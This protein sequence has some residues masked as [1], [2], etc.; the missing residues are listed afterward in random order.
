MSTKLVS[1][2]AMT[3]RPIKGIEPTAYVISRDSLKP[4]L[5]EN[6]VN[7]FGITGS[8]AE[9]QAVKFGFNAGSEQVTSDTKATGYKHTFS[10]VFAKGN[11]NLDTLDNIVVVVKQQGCG[12]QWLCYGLQNGLYKTGHTKKANDNSG[13]TTIEFASRQD[14]EEDFSEYTL[15]LDAIADI[16]T[17]EQLVNY[18]FITGLFLADGGVT[19]QAL[20]LETDADKTCFVILPDGTFIEAVAGAID[21]SWTGDAGEITIIIEKTNEILDLTGSDLFGSANFIVN[22]LNQIIVQSDNLSTVEMDN[23]IKCLITS[24]QVQG[25][26]S[27]TF[28]DNGA[29][30]TSALVSIAE[31]LGWTVPFTAL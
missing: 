2:I 26:H 10:G 3:S 30:P 17:F 25:S 6:A 20:A 13:M 28:L 7:Q 31:G 4:I 27:L 23:M 9:W 19:P 15:N 8:F 12:G 24:G 21:E 11:A 1:N 14:M 22:S 16:A 18:S 29:V 5:T